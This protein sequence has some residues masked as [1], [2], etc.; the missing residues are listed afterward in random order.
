MRKDKVVL[1]CAAIL[2]CACNQ[3]KFTPQEATLYCGDSIKVSVK[4]EPTAQLVSS[5]PFVASVN[6]TGWVKAQH[7]GEAKIGSATYMTNYN[8]NSVD[9]NT[10]NT[11]DYCRVTVKPR[12][13]YYEEPMKDWDIT[14]DEVI[15]Q[16]GNPSQVQRESGAEVLV[17]G[18]KNKDSYVTKYYF[19]GSR[20]DAALIVTETLTEAQLRDFLNERYWT[21]QEEDTYYDSCN[22]YFYY[23]SDDEET[24]TMVVQLDN[25]KNRGVIEVAYYKLEWVDPAW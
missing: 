19:S 21:D 22:E 10:Q 11:N 3:S 16:L 14:K 4:D 24:M 2:L 9:D 23:D 15:R 25:Y 8:S 18:D 13:E 20:L 17:Y 6:G 12:Y 5:A 1:L 7:V